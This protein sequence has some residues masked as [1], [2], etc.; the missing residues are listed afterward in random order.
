MT[1]KNY[2]RD[3]G[4]V[5]DSQAGRRLIYDLIQCVEHNP[6]VVDS[7]TATYYN[8]GKQE[9]ARFL[10]TRLKAKHYRSYML[11]MHEQFGDEDDTASACIEP[12]DG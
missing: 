6:T 12:E 9:S 3:L 2:D 4:V 8:L 10:A 5:M 11:M 7:P 1:Y